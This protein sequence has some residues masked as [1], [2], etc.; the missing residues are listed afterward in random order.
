MKTIADLKPDPLNP[1]KIEQEA[2]DG[3]K[4]SLESFGDLSGIV[5]NDT[6]GH[7]V[8]GHQ[9]VSQ[10]TSLYG[11]LPIKGGEIKCPNGDVFRVRTVE[12]PRE[13]ELAANIAANNQAIAGSFDDSLQGLLTELKTSDQVMFDR[14]QFA[15]LDIADVQREVDVNLVR[16]D[17]KPPPPMTWVLVGIETTRYGEIAGMIDQVLAH[18]GVIVE[19]TVGPAIDDI[20]DED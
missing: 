2:A 13:K 1:R 11:E 6:T 17:V 7:L 10:L 15:T 12:W 3:L 14:L 4:Y 20:E 16:L 5:F 8:C 19:T 9:R 18:K